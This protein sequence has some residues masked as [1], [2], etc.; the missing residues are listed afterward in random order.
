MP[1]YFK[2][3]QVHLPLLPDLIYDKHTLLLLAINMLS[4]NNFLFKYICVQHVA[5]TSLDF[6]H[7]EYVVWI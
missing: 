4:V 1:I 2:R 7:V 3:S 5:Y 6:R